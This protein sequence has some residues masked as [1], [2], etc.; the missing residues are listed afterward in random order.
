MMP[1]LC[2]MGRWFVGANTVACE[3]LH[4]AFTKR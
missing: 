1:R 4:I 3:L 2:G